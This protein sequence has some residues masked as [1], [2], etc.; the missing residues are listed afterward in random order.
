VGLFMV[1]GFKFRNVSLVFKVYQ[2]SYNSNTAFRWDFFALLGGLCAEFDVMFSAEVK[3]CGRE[4]QILSS[5]WTHE[6]LLQIGFTVIV[7]GLLRE[8]LKEDRVV[9]V[10]KSILDIIIGNHWLTTILIIYIK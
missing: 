5:T 6:N 8:L 4:T 1:T 9:E 7:G 10:T 3:I 2:I